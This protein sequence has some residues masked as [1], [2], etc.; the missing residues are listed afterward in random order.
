MGLVDRVMRSSVD[1]AMK[2]QP[3]RVRRIADET[4]YATPSERPRVD[5]IRA[6]CTRLATARFSVAGLGLVATSR[7]AGGLTVTEAGADFTDVD[8]RHLVTWSPADA[9]DD[10]DPR[11]SL[12]AT[13]YSAIAGG[14]DIDAVVVAHPPHVLAAAASGRLPG[15][16][17]GALGSV[18]GPIGHGPIDGPGVWVIDAGVAAA[19]HNAVDAVRRLEAA[20]RIAEI[21]MIRRNDG[22]D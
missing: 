20:D 15:A 8:A 4:R 13:L 16:F 5:E 9:G 2:M 21:D 14:G 12:L 10:V 22:H 18:A 19:G 7:E 11:H 3:R 6:A 17:D 1:R